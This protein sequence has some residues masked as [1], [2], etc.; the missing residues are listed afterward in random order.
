MARPGR[1]RK[2]GVKR[3]PSGGIVQER[4][5]KIAVESRARL[6][7]VSIEQAR[8]QEAGTF[9]GLLHLRGK[10]S[11]EHLAASKV[12]DLARENYLRAIDARRQRSGSDYSSN[13]SYDDSPGDDPSYI[14]QYRLAVDR[15]MLLRDEIIRRNNRKGLQ[16]LEHWLTLTEGGAAD[17]GDLDLVKKALAVIHRMIGSRG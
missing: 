5:D 13:G 6:S 2:Q 11:K 16:R 12:F 17:Q 3:N 14:R 8:T 7:G 15:Y 4:S 1:K 10:I 9:L